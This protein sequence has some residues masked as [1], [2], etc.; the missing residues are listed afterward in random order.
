MR[1]PKSFKSAAKHPSL[2]AVMDEEIQAFHHNHT[3]DLV[4]PPPNKNV[5]G[6][7]WI[8]YIKYLS[9]GTVDHPKARHVAKGYTQQPSLDFIDT[10]SLVIKASMVRVV[11][12]L[13]VSNN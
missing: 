3:W 2:I 4:P 6:F 13:A 1:K 10:F 5:V 8:F 12:S 9:D 7:K 11:L